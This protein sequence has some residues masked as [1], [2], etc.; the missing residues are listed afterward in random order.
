MNSYSI[1]NTQRKLS[2]EA[3]LPRFRLPSCSKR[4]NMNNWRSIFFMPECWAFVARHCNHDH[5]RKVFVWGLFCS[6]DN[7]LCNINEFL[8]LKVIPIEPI[9]PFVKP[10]VVQ[11][12]RVNMTLAPSMR[13]NFSASPS[14]SLSDALLASG[15]LLRAGN[16][17]TGFP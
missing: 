13:S 5:C 15:P 1:S 8:E 11:I 12:F 16:V 14:A 7:T 3:L 17:R 6:K 2:T 10:F 9:D 4:D